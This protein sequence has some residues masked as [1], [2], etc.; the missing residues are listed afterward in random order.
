MPQEIRLCSY[1]GCTAELECKGLCGYHY[2]KKRYAENPEVRLR[3]NKLGQD[4]HRKHADRYRTKTWIYRLKARYGLSLDQYNQL[5]LSQ[6]GGCAICGQ[7]STLQRRLD[8]DHNHKTGKVRGLLCNTCNQ[9]MGVAKD[10]PDLLRKM[11]AYLDKH[12]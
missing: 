6:Q 12:N 9:A 8:V 7:Q 4:W 10:S 2:R 1:E 3:N 11:A 5:L